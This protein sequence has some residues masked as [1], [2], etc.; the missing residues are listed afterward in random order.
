LRCADY[1]DLWLARRAKNIALTTVATAWT[2]GPTRVGEFEL[3]RRR[4]DDFTNRYRAWPNA[5]DNA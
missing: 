2:C 4:A 5:V 3:S 1:I